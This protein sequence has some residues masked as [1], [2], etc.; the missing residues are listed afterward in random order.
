MFTPHGHG[1]GRQW[2]CCPFFLMV[3]DD[4]YDHNNGSKDDI[5]DHHYRQYRLY[6]HCCVTT[7]MIISIITY[8]K[9][10]VQHHHRRPLPCPWGVN[11]NH[12]STSCFLTMPMVIRHS[13]H[14]T[15]H[16]HGYPPRLSLYGPCPWSSATIINSSATIITLRATPMVIRHSYITTPT[17]RHAT[18]LGHAQVSVIVIVLRFCLHVHT[19]P[20]LYLFLLVRRF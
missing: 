8:H 5:G 9:K 17:D 3:G 6:C 4:G 15:G 11:K 12:V 10:K 16:A 14:S 2:R 18:P 1:K 13:Y 19:T 7:V 20:I